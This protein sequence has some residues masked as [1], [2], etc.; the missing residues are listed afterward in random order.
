MV[1]IG[2]DSD[3][4]KAT[5]DWE[6]DS[7]NFVQDQLDAINNI[8]ETIKS[9]EFYDRINATVQ[10][11]ISQVPSKIEIYIDTLPKLVSS[12]FRREGI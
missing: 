11:V 2:V 3:V 4:F 6:S 9:Y 5:N 12:L 1:A 10:D 8:E 7:V